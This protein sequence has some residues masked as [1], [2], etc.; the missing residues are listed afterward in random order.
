MNYTSSI[1]INSNIRF[2]KPCI[3]GTRIAVQDILGWLAAGMSV[4]EICED[5]PELTEASIQA[6]LGYAADKER[7]ITVAV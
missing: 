2:G 6:A 1:N 5:F 3:V 7:R 4:Q